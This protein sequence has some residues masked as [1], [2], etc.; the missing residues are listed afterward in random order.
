VSVERQ[1]GSPANNAIARQAESASLVIVI[2]AI[3][4]SLPSGHAHALHYTQSMG[5]LTALG[6][7]SYTGQSKAA[8]CCFD[9]AWQVCSPVG[10]TFFIEKHGGMAGMSLVSSIQI[11]FVAG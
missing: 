9:V 10:L 6:R 3:D 4:V 1:A 5:R 2:L 11:Q 7:S 8:R